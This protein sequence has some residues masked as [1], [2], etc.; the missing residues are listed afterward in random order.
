[1]KKFDSQLLRLKTQLGIS[2]DQGVAELLGM[3]KAAFSD[4]K[5]R[6]S[7][8]EDKLRALVSRRPDLRI[9]PDFVIRGSDGVVFLEMKERKPVY[10]GE[11]SQLPSKT[12][13][14]ERLLRITEMLE[15]HAKAAGRRWPAQK[16]IKTAIEVYNF[17][18]AEDAVDD[19]KIERVLRLVVK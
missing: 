13:D 12:I 19:S 9:D 3:S 6:D 8:P 10:H 18:A 4:R 14:A 17:L 1:M 5:K 2:D 7:F 11:Q 15:G 16:L